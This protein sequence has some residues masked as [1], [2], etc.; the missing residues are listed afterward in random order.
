MAILIPEEEIAAAGL[1]A[2]IAKGLP[3]AVSLVSLLFGHRPSQ[4][5]ATNQSHAWVSLIAGPV[6]AMGKLFDQTVHTFESTYNTLNAVQARIGDAYNSLRSLASRWVSELRRYVDG[7]VQYLNDR[8]GSAYN[9]SLRVTS[10]WVTELRTYT[11]GK[12]QYLN[13]RIGAAYNQSLRVTSGWVHDLDVKVQREIA[14]T[15]DRIGAAYNQ[16]LKVTSGW[17]ITAQR[18]TTATITDAIV[19]PTRATWPIL[20]TELAA[21]T[22]AAGPELA[23]V[24]ALIKAVPTRAP[25]TIAEAE[26]APLDIT[27][28]LTRVMT[29]CTI[30]NC[31]NLSKYGRDLHGL[32][33]LL[34]G[35][36]LLAFVAYAV[37][38][39]H[40]AAQD[41]EDVVSPIIDGTAHAVETIL[42]V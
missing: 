41:T 38:H 34:A 3:I 15:N 11:D 39:P 13:D 23:D 42:G 16:A 36:G 14:V 20:V 17:V 4:S 27:R 37:A 40:E 10:K 22:E 7:K 26:S 35:A 8:I 28:V 18:E 21:A 24:R 31:R 29:D 19:K 1:R 5:E 9:Q 33:D 2:W 32:G 12:V 25:G 30:P 6:K